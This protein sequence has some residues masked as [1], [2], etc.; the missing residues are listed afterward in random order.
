MSFQVELSI[1]IGL[2]ATPTHYTNLADGNV[3]SMHLNL[4]RDS[5]WWS[6][7]LQRHKRKL[8]IGFMR[9]TWWWGWKI[10]FS[11]KWPKLI[12]E[13]FVL[14]N[15]FS[16]EPGLWEEQAFVVFAHPKRNFCNGYIKIWWWFY[17]WFSYVRGCF[18]DSQTNILTSHFSD[19]TSVKKP[20]FLGLF[21]VKK[22]NLKKLP[23]EATCTH[24][25]YK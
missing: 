6:V 23:T 5:W 20:W 18:H 25:C 12:M 3:A 21:L 4:W 15:P 22:L 11:G 19:Q 14:G 9:R 24:G 1:R 7:F 17:F 16:S 13:T 10:W 8:C 2:F